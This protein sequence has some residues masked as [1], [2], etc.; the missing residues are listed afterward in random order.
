MFILYFTSIMNW[1]NMSDLLGVEK[2]SMM[3]NS[4]VLT[5]NESVFYHIVA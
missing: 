5:Y 2:I 3:G 1:F 4:A